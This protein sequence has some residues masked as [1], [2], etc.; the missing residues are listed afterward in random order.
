MYDI[1]GDKMGSAIASACATHIL[2]DPGNFKTADE[3]SKRY[4]EKEVVVRSRSTSVNSGL[5]ASRSTSWNESL[6]KVPLISPDE[7]LRFEEGKCIITNP[8]Y[9]SRGEGSVPYR[10]KIPISPAEIN[11]RQQTMQLWA[12]VE[13]KLQQR[14]Q[15]VGEE[16]LTQALYDRIAAAE[17][18]LPL[19]DSEDSAPQTPNP[20]KMTETGKVSEVKTP[21]VASNKTAQ[22][23]AA[24]K[25]R[26]RP[27]VR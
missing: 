22:N 1:Y 10:L 17:E 12:T 21:E 19:P 4:G 7:I 18:L 27:W 23:Q 8:A 13:Q 2:F 5:H 20:V 16:S 3:Y 26:F 14:V 6:Q 15:L 11:R 25:A 24:P 9:R